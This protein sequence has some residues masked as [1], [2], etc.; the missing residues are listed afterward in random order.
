MKVKTVLCSLCFAISALFSLSQAAANPMF[1]ETAM[2]MQ[3]P[4]SDH[5]QLTFMSDSGYGFS[6]ALPFGVVRE[7]TDNIL[8]PIGPISISANNGSGITSF[9]AIQFC[10]CAVEPGN[11]TYCFLWEGEAPTYVEECAWA[12]VKIPPPGWED[13]NPPDGDDD[14]DEDQ[15]IRP[16][17]IPDGPW[18]KG[19]NC[20]DWCRDNPDANDEYM[21]NGPMADGDSII[22]PDGDAASS[23]G[24]G[25]ASDGDQAADGDQ[26]VMQED[27]D[28]PID[29]EGADGDGADDDGTNKDG[30]EGA[31]GSGGGNCSSVGSFSFSCFCLAAILA[32]ALLRRRRREL[33]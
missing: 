30:N 5:V 22:N 17:E 25:A 23:D 3:Y 32:A 16:W 2:G 11:Y 1:Y 24:D 31:D 7:E 20:I 27:G 29:D 10:D 33:L 8:M 6:G 15:E 19:V 13:Y 28:E 18:P 12:S 9:E 26:P 14:G 21:P 4:E